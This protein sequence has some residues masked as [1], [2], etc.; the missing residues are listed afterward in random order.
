MNNQDIQTIIDQLEEVWTNISLF[1]DHP[2]YVEYFSD[3]D[4]RL[5]ENNR[6][7]LRIKVWDN[8]TV[9][10]WGFGSLYITR[11][12]YDHGSAVWECSVSWVTEKQCQRLLEMNGD[13]NALRDE[14][15]PDLR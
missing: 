13:L 9:V 1:D 14:S 12:T 7:S 6:R 3:N 15:N 5:G 11:T 4:T 10:T 2:F 8:R